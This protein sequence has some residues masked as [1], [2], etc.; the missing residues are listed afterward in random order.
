M[1]LSKD[2]QEF[3][4]AFGSSYKMFSDAEYKRQQAATSEQYRKDQIDVARE[5]LRGAPAEELAGA[6][7]IRKKYETGTGAPGEGGSAHVPSTKQQDALAAQ[8]HGYLTDKLGYSPEA[9]AGILGNMKQES[10]FDP[11]AGGDKEG[12]QA[13]AHG[14]FQWR[15]DRFT[16]LQKFAA[17]QGK[18]WKD[19]YTQ[20]DFMDHEL[21][22]G[23]YGKAYQALQ[24]AKTASQAADGFALHFERPK[25]ANTGDPNQIHGIGARRGYANQVLGFRKDV[26]GQPRTEP[27]VSSAPL[28]APRTQ[29]TEAPPTAIP[30]KPKPK[31][32]PAPEE[33]AA[34]IPEPDEDDTE[35]G[36]FA[37]GGAV[38]DPTGNYGAPRA[39][40]QAPT[41]QTQPVAS[42]GGSQVGG[43]G[44]VPRRVGQ[45]APGT[46]GQSA[47]PMP[48]GVGYGVGQV[49]PGQQAL[50]DRRQ[51]KVDA[52]NAAAAAAAAAATKPVAGT[53]KNQWDPRYGNRPDAGN[54]TMPA[55]YQ[56]PAA[57][58][59]QLEAM[60][61]SAFANPQAFIAMHP[62]SE[63]YVRWRVG[64]DAWGAGQRQQDQWN[65]GG[66]ESGYA[67]GGL[68]ERSYAAGGSVEE[69]DPPAPE[70]AP[71][72]APEFAL[73]PP[74]P[75]KELPKAGTIAGSKAGLPT[76]GTGRARA[77]GELTKEKQ[78]D[79]DSPEAAVERMKARAEARLKLLRGTEPKS[80]VEDVKA[81]G[82]ALT[83]PRPAVVAE[84]PGQEQVG[85]LPEGGRA[86]I[87]PP[88]GPVQ[89]SPAGGGRRPEVLTPTQTADPNVRREMDLEQQARQRRREALQAG[90]M[91]PNEAQQPILTNEQRDPRLAVPGVRPYAPPTTPAI[92]GA[93]T[94]QVGTP[95]AEEPGMEVLRGAI[96]TGQVQGVEPAEAMR[97]PGPM[98]PKRPPQAELQEVPGKPSPGQPIL[99]PKGDGSGQ[100][101][102]VTSL[103]RGYDLHEQ[104]ERAKRAKRGAISGTDDPA[105]QAD[106]RNY[107]RGDHVMKSDEVKAV[108][109]TVDPHR[110]MTQGDRNIAMYQELQDYW[111]SKGRPD[112]AAEASLGL[113]MYNRR[114]AQATGGMALAALDKGDVRSAAQW[115]SK[116]FNYVPNNQ[117][118]HV[119]QDFQTQKDKDGKEIL[120]KDG[121]PVPMKGP[122]G[123]PILLDTITYRLLDNATG[124]EIEVG[125]ADRGQLAAMAQ[126]VM[127]GAAFDQQIW[128][129]MAG[130][131]GGATAKGPSEGDKKAA[132][133]EEF[134]KLRTEAVGAPDEKTRREKISRLRA[135]GG[136][137]EQTDKAIRRIYTEAGLP[138]PPDLEREGKAGKAA[139]TPLDDKAITSARVAADKAR[140]AL[141]ADPENEELKR[142]YNDKASALAAL[143]PPKIRD[144]RMKGAGH[145]PKNYQTQEARPSWVPEGARKGV[146]KDGKETW[147]ISEGGKWKK[148][149]PKEKAEAGA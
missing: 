32:A 129:T 52:A 37:A 115:L 143:F 24:G 78:E 47:I 81:V 119:S 122:D 12:G 55:G 102:A 30:V 131:K 87:P 89:E 1:S 132:D 140:D 93:P 99:D 4:S 98:P 146:D 90:S 51:A 112:K 139:E 117:S 19:A 35:T 7:G 60:P 107:G 20:L 56:R 141:K 50:R 82:A 21:K 17:D 148:L 57:T 110:Q 138:V 45:A 97:A 145:D 69:E 48:A 91:A 75:A 54:P 120:D 5:R 88:P 147:F 62:G 71:A 16:N 18:S 36:S 67:Q 114:S 109:D 26:A 42:T 116:G 2:L 86:A 128:N 72:P 73:P 121:Y 10:S 76:G 92:A 101:Q 133:R 74:E 83:E 66:R 142:A 9:A 58:T 68:V 27:G 94:L 49:T 64:E 84:V 6:E 44:F 126:G 96:P 38:P 134:E 25:G 28:A 33:D 137:N 8:Y 144:T 14:L 127:S 61:D 118:L 106:A 11:L 124:K 23:G 135:I 43:T 3:T 105:A 100:K 125:H 22:R 29:V 46:T 41:A 34:L 136:A 85:A 149:T 80:P 13:T 113:T 59:E 77:S 15:G 103:K 63:N 111:L 70:P 79:H 108:A 39:F 53:G 31:A 40:T 130:R 65:R 123:K 104:E 95:P